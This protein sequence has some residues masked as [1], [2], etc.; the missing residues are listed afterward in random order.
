MPDTK[1][2]RERSGRNKRSQ[3]QQK[4]YEA[5]VDALS[6]DED[7]PPFESSRDR[8]FLADELPDSG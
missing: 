1:D 2:G 3:L 6:A 4:L 8:P 7:L 5:E